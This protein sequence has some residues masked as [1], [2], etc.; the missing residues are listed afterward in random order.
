MT[1]AHRLPP[2]KWRKEYGLL[3]TSAAQRRACQTR[4]KG[5]CVGCGTS[6]V[7]WAA[8]HIQALHNLPPSLPFPDA[9]R[10]WR[11][12]NLQTLCR[13]RCHRAKTI[14]E[15][16]A[17]AKVKRIRRRLDGTRRPRAMIKSRPLKRPTT[18][19]KPTPTRQ[20]REQP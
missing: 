13:D 14:G 9:L 1:P 3:L 10:Y 16:K 15:V 17:N 4:D 6:G 12:E 19:F 2:L 18:I 20:I 5:V 8:D 7:P 11:I